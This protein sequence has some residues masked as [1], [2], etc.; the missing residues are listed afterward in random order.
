VD[1]TMRVYESVK[2]NYYI[3]SE[4]SNQKNLIVIKVVDG[5]MR[6]YENIKGNDYII[7]ERGNT[8]KIQI[9]SSLCYLCAKNH[10]ALLIPTGTTP[11]PP[12][13]PAPT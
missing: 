7:L 11:P 1:G 9:K 12:L 2:G 8:S 13:P 5:T 3:I 6:I 4:E 10:S